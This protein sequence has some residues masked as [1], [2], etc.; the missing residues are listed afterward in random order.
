MIKLSII[1]PAWATP[2]QLLVRCLQS[3]DRFRRDMDVDVETIVV[4]DKG[5]QSELRNIGLARASGDWIWFVDADDEVVCESKIIN[6]VRHT[7]ADIIIFGY[8]QRWGK[9]GKRMR[10]IPSMQFD[11]VLGDVHMRR[12]AR[13]VMFRALWNKLYRRSFLVEKSIVFDER[14]EPC[15]DGIFNI[16]CIF[17][18]A[19]WCRLDAI[20][21]V[22]WRRLDSSL[23]RYTPTLERAIARE[24]ALWDELSHL[25]GVKAFDDCK[26]SAKERMFM[27][28]N[29]MLQGNA[30]S[31]VSI[32]MR[33]RRLALFV[34]RAL[35]FVGI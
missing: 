21:Y 9:I 31:S 11:G 16:R 24:D 33:A 25:M 12:V 32:L 13:S 23:F 2:N 29:N 30:G 22:Y 6:A 27:I 10:H 5:V 17:A 1:I 19:K 26:L 15:E 8:E 20:G 34:R 14:T 18:G 28:Q 4:R 7:D 35:R 3:V